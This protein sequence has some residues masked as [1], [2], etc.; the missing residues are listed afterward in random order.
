VDDVTVNLTITS[1]IILGGIGFS[2]M[3]DIRENRR[4]SKL[5]LHT[6]L[7]LVTSAVLI[8]FGMITIL[9]LEWDNPDTLQE[10]TLKGK[11]LA[12]Y[13]QSV[14][15]RTA[16]YNTVDI[17]KMGSATLFFIIM[18]MFIGAS[19]GSTGGGIKTSTFGVLTAAIWALI[20]GKEDVEMFE[21][22]I[23]KS[24]VYK[25][26]ALGFMASVLVIVVTMIMSI[27]EKAP[28]LSILFEVVSAFGT[29]GLSTGIT[30]ALTVHGKLWLIITMFTGRV[31]PVTLALALA[32]R[33]GRTLVQYPEGKAI[34]G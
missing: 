25:A 26:F 4:F 1:L 8:L 20:R 22:K 14:T 19:P 21:R 17:G 28:F 30:P 7:V 29:V 32:M 18:L 2:V 34:I 33:Q 13:F 15:P 23:P 24:L 5:T 9:A 27:T 16:G 10:L 11:V 3:A 6:R 31:G 12:S